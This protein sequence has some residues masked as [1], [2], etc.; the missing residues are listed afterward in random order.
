MIYPD[1]WDSDEVRRMCGERTDKYSLGACSVRWAYIMA[2]M[3]I[4][5]AMILSFLAFV[6]GNRQ[7]GLMSEELLADSKGSLRTPP[8][9]LFLHILHPQ[10]K[11]VCTALSKREHVVLLLHQPAIHHHPTS[12]PASQP[13]LDRAQDTEKLHKSAELRTLA[14]VTWLD[15][16]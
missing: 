9:S 8:P 13:H 11:E 4:L 3:G 5:N 16:H 1:G 14:S 12:Q 15:H 7:N 6:L 2:I 10:K